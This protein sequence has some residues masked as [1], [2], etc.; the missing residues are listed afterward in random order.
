[1]EGQQL[2]VYTAQATLTW[3]KVTDD[4]WL[5]SISAP[6]L[7]LRSTQGTFIELQVSC[8]FF[9]NKKELLFY[10]TALPRIVGF[11]LILLYFSL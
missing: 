3:L 5:I 10:S 8:L 6:Y 9:N 7:V 11:P 1:M 4:A 2:A